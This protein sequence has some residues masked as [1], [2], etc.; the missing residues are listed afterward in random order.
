MWIVAHYL[1][2][3]FFSLRPASATSSGGQTLLVP[4]PFAIKMALLSTLIRTRGLAEGERLFPALRDLP[5]ALEPPEQA[6]VIKGFSKIRRELKDK[7][8]PEKAARARLE[9]EYPFQP[10]IAYRE[11]ISYYGSLRLAC[12]V[13]EGSPLVTVLPELLVGLNYLGKRGG[14]IQIL[15]PPQ[16]SAEL[17][18]GNF[19]L[20]TA[21]RQETFPM[22]GTL[23]VLDDCGPK[24]TF[25]QANIYTNERIV[26]N[27]DRVLRHVVL[28]YQ[29]WRSSH[30]YS[31]YRLL[32][33]S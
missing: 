24:L 11:Y 27:R 33:S 5:I 25:A 18:A 12:E 20:L 13:A 32:P 31:W 29:R 26:L 17:P 28:P 22:Q 6:V 4:T 8:N 7:S 9:K 19:L 21:S 16:Q 1:P 3:S 15:Q 2:V 10:T 23:Q 14:F 30:A